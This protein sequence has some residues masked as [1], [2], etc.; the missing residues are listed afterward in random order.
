MTGIPT[1]NVWP[2]A[3]FSW[4]CTGCELAAAFAGPVLGV[5]LGFVGGAVVDDD[6]L[7][8]GLLE[9]VAGGVVDGPEE[10]E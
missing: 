4:M 2:S 5:V 7:A 9:V 10:L 6:A 8:G 3:N 1:P